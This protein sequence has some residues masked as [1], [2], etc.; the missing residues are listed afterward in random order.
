MKM[1]DLAI[2]L[3]GI[4]VIFA[5][6]FLWFWFMDL[7]EK[8]ET[9]YFEKHPAVNSYVMEGLIP[10]TECFRALIMKKEG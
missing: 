8:G 9:I 3:L 6:A 1:N 10:F 4:T 2:I 7:W 5:F